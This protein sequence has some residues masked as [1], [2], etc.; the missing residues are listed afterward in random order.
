M[1]P[2][3][4]TDSYPA[5]LHI[6]LRENPEKPQRDYKVVSP[7]RETSKEEKFDP[8]LWIEF[9][10][11][12]WSERLPHG[13]RV[14]NQNGKALKDFCAHNEMRITNSYFNHR[15]IHKFTWSQRGLRSIIDYVLVNRKLVSSIQDT[16]VFRGSDFGSDHFL[17]VAKLVLFKRWWRTRTKE[18]G[19]PIET[20]KVNLFREKSIREL[21][22]KRMKQYMEDIEFYDNINQNWNELENILHKTATEVLGKKKKKKTEKRT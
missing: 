7:Q 3:S 18:K 21:Y 15:E 16:R 14:E 9:G 12:Q 13:E 6:G 2:G 11:A 17:L 22:S 5:F 20:Y 19:K 4:S 10:V 1:S 8:L